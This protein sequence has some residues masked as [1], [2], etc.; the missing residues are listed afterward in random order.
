MPPNLPLFVVANELFDP[1]EV[2]LL[3]AIRIVFDA[4]GLTD[5]FKKF[6]GTFLS[7][8]PRSKG[9]NDAAP[10]SVPGCSSRVRR[11]LRVLSSCEPGVPAIH[12]AG[13]VFLEYEYVY[14]TELLSCPE[15]H[16]IKNEWLIYF[17]NT[18]IGNKLR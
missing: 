1:T 13:R 12:A 18:F 15:E 2:T 6:H 8:K 7:K 10:V 5:L 17:H 9:M 4:E 11:C 14:T 16:R 3:G